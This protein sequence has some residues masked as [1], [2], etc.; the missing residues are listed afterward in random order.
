MS[1]HELVNINGVL[2]LDAYYA[3]ND[4]EDRACPYTS[5]PHKYRPDT[6]HLTFKMAKSQMSIQELRLLTAEALLG[7]G[8]PVNGADI[9]G[10]QLKKDGNPGTLQKTEHFYSG[11][12]LPDWG[13]EIVREFLVTLGMFA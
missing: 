7:E 11:D 5:K 8:S 2:E 13:Q 12:R 9:I 3:I 10:N 6:L 4:V 1:H